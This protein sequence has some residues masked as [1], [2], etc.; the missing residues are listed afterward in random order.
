VDVGPLTV[1]FSYRTP[2]AFHTYETGLVVRE[3]DWSNTTGRHLNYIDDGVKGKRI[4]GAA[5][6]EQ[7]RALL[8][9]MEY[10]EPASVD[11]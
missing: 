3:N 4:S 6:E 8:S 7:L 5:F 1:W 10:H 11:E 9:R 2:V